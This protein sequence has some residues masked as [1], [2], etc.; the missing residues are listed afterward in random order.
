MRKK[1]GANISKGEMKFWKGEWGMR[2]EKK[3]KMG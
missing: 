2:D 3:E 1:G